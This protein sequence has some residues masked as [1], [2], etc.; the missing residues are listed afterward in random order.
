MHIGILSAGNGWHVRD[1]QRAALTL[2]HE[3]KSVDFRHIQATLPAQGTSLD[4]FDSVLVRTMPPGSLEQVV[5]RMDILH[6]LQVKGTRVLNPPR[7]LE[8]CID[9]YLACARLDA[10]GLSVPKTVVCQDAEAAL[11]AFSQMGGDV[12]VKPL[13][14]SEGRGLIRV[15]DFEMAWRCFR[16]LEEV[17]SVLYLQEFI[18]HPGW[19][20]RVLVIGDR[21]VAAM[22][23]HARNDWRTNV[24]Q[25]GRAESVTADKRGGTPRHRRR[26]SRR[27]ADRRCRFV[28]EPGGRLFCPRG[29]CR[30]R[31]ASPGGG[32]GSRR[33]AGTDAVC[34]KTALIGFEPR[35]A[36]PEAGG[37]D[38]QHV[39]RSTSA[40][41][42]PP[43]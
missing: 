10:A 32:H 18:R 41:P 6:R 27:H 9:K 21:A 42:S 28:A 15:S 39:L 22:R 12:V 3:A 8:T 14:G 1:L 40:A 30:S 29:E 38:R 13:F 16:A 20:L 5:L 2:G 19:D 35:V 25:G 23:R 34:D 37:R 26:Q 7:A 4:A 31:L 33:R 36:R 43:S 11:A 24:A 17:R